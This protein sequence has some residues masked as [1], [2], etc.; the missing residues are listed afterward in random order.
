MAPQMLLTLMVGFLIYV[1]FRAV[2]YFRTK[3]PAFGIAVVF[4]GCIVLY[5]IVRL[6]MKIASGEG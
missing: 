1:V 4:V 6:I 3:R 5:E 2:V